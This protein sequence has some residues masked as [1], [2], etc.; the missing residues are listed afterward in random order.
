[1]IDD[2]TRL[3]HAALAR[4]EAYKYHI[5]RAKAAEREYLMLCTVIQAGTLTVAFTIPDTP[6]EV[7]EDD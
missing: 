2:L 3:Q 4:R 7:P 6:P 1:M 5:A